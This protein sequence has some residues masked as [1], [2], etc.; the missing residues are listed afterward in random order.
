M[1]KCWIPNEVFFDM[2]MAG[3]FPGPTPSLTQPGG[4]RLVECT[5]QMADWCRSQAV[6][7]QASDPAR[8]DLFLKVASLIDKALASDKGV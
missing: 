6:Q 5:P 4:Q 1:G 8:A 3:L 7:A 2:D